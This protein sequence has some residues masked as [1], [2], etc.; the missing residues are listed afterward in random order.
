[1]VCQRKKDHRGKKLGDPTRLEVPDRRWGSLAC[2]FIVNLPRSRN[3]FESITTNVDRFRDEFP[4]FH[5]NILILQWMLQTTSF[6][7]FLRI[8]ASQ[9]VLFQ[10]EISNSLRAFW[11]KSM[12]LCAIKLKISSSIHPQTDGSSEI[13]NR[14][15]E[16]YLRC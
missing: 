8:T 1:M 3:G 4:V 2:D 11:E 7:I 6:L 12:K 14:K 13:M 10:I 16:N 15:I 5:Q 9:T